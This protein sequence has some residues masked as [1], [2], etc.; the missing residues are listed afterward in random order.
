MR[1]LTA[2]KNIIEIKDAMAGVV[3][4]LHYR[5]PTTSERVKF[6]TQLFE[7]RGN[8]IINRALATQEKF[9]ALILEGFKKGTISVDG[10]AIAADPDD[11]DYYPEWKELM[12]KAAPELLAVVARVAFDGAEAVHRPDQP[13]EIVMEE[14]EEDLGE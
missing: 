5:T 6:R 4:E 14:L 7:R 12:T 11:P 10:K 8:K 2:T 9:G 13:A 1:D 3:H